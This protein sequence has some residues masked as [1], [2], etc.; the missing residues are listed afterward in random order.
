MPNADVRLLRKSSYRLLTYYTIRGGPDD[1][2][3]ITI[4][5]PLGFADDPETP[6]SAQRATDRER[7]YRESTN[8]TLDD[9]EAWDA[10]Q[11]AK[12]R[13]CIA[14][15]RRTYAPET[16]TAAQAEVERLR[17]EWA[18]PPVLP[19]YRTPWSP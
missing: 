8:A 9:L 12:A 5:P 18:T 16:I 17:A 3:E 2:R 6:A 1:G 19:E 4:A 11:D 13:P 15:R 7:A 10:E 14:Y